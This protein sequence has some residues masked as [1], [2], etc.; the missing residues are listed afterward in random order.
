MMNTAAN[1]VN[2]SVVTRNIR[3]QAVVGKHMESLKEGLKKFWKAFTD[4]EIENTYGL[5]PDMQAK[6]YL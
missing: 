4:T 5:S 1:A 2:N 6:L 3:T